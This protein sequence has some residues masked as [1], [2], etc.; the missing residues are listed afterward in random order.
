MKK[1]IYLFAPVLLLTLTNT[2]CDSDDDT[3]VIVNEEEV[4][5]TLI[6]NLTPEGG[7]STLQFQS[8]DLDG[9]GPDAPVVTTPDQSLV[10]NTAYTG[11]VLILNETEDPADNITLEV[12]EEDDEHQFFYTT[13]GGLSFA[14]FNYL[15]FDE[16]GNPVGIDFNFTTGDA[17]TGTL[18][19]TLL[20]ELAKPNDGL[21]SAGG[22]TDIAVTFPVTVE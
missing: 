3:P 20:H 8:Q 15:D 14:G 17:A 2:S 22:D 7:G 11:S 12:A 10:A 4:I 18:T 13:G 6:V 16:N 19:V 1:L 5:T 9:D 21:A